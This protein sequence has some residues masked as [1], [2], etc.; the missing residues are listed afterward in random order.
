[1]GVGPPAPAT[2]V[3]RHARRASSA[4]LA[5]MPTV[6]GWRLAGSERMMAL[7][8]NPS[9]GVAAPATTYEPAVPSRAASAASCAARRCSRS[10]LRAAALRSQD[11]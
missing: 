7:T 5:F 2:S 1:M 6:G 4:C 8:L 11:S 10:A 3:S 9:R